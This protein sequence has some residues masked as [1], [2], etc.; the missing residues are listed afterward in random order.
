VF[1]EGGLV[2]IEGTMPG[3]SFKSGKPMI[4]NRLDPNEIPPEM[5]QKASAEGL[6]SF[7]DIPLISKDR[8]L[9]VLAV[10]RREEDGFDRIGNPKCNQLL[11]HAPHQADG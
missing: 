1:T 4:V 7:C 5:V 11:L 9:G 2:P 8:L 6:N 3:E 10:A